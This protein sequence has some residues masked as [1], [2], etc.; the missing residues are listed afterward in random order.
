MKMKKSVYWA[1]IEYLY[2]KE[3]PRYAELE[4]GFVNVFLYTEDASTFFHKIQSFFLDEKL[5]IIKIEFI[6]VYDK[7]MKWEKPDD[8]KRYK[9]IYKEAELTGEVVLDDFYAYKR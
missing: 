8:T 5:E 2:T 7:K 9:N 6:N 4:G 1:D 3:H